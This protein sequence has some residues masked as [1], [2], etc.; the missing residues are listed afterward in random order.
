M[1]ISIQIKGIASTS[2]FLALKSKEATEKAEAAIKKAGFFIEDEV[3]Q[4]I[5]G[6]RAEN[7]SVDTGH[8]MG[9]I[10]AVFPKKLTANIGCNKYP[11]AYA[12]NLEYN[13]N[14]IGGPRAHFRNTKTRNE[15][16]VQEFVETEIK[17][18]G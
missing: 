11:V 10:L 8:F 18:V 1:S 13:P 3:V 5:S 14:I 2:A 16:K 9:S 15:K 6:R 12:D 17:K 4:S 7:R